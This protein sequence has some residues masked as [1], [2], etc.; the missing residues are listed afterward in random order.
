MKT[1]MKIISSLTLTGALAIGGL[2]GPVNLESKAMAASSVSILKYPIPTKENQILDYLER[3]MYEFYEGTKVRKET[4]V[5]SELAEQE[6]AKKSELL[7]ISQLTYDALVKYKKDKKT[8]ETKAKQTYS[9]TLS[10]LDAETKKIKQRYEKKVNT[11][12]KYRVDEINKIAKAES[13]NI[14]SMRSTEIKRI[15]GNSGKEEIKY[16]IELIEKAVNSYKVEAIELKFESLIAEY[17]SK[18][19]VAELEAARKTKELN[20]QYKKGSLTAKQLKTK[21]S[22]IEESKVAE[23]ENI[24]RNI[25]G[26]IKEKNLQVQSLI[27][28]KETVIAQIKKDN[29]LVL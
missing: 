25:D 4:S 11:L 26:L 10:S 16:N 12:E 5:N 9:K 1:I 27:K 20:F 14:T 29:N 22:N 7:Q 13:Y 15:S 24:Q 18:R 23:Q 19:K 2:I 3:G 21:Q 8:N 6:E 17:K 28:L